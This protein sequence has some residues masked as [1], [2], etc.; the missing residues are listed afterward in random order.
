M[1]PH[2]VISF[3]TGMR[4]LDYF[5]TDEKREL[6]VKQV[7]REVERS[8]WD[9][10]SLIIEV[11]FAAFATTL[12]VALLSHFLQLP[13]NLER[14]VSYLAVGVVAFLL[15]RRSRRRK[16]PHLLRQKLVEQ[17]VPM[18]LKCGYNLRG[19]PADST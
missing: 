5:E 2:R 8:S 6:A 18:C 16:Y 12:S 10:W 4:E 7:E 13:R 17:G 19:Q 3:F 11:S 15:V 9:F 14:G 1:K